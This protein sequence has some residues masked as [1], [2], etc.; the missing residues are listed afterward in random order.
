MEIWHDTRAKSCRC[1]G[2]VQ[3]RQVGK[4][5]F[6][7]SRPG[8]AT[9]NPG[10][11]RAGLTV[12]FAP[13]STAKEKQERTTEP[14]TCRDRGQGRMPSICGV[15]LSHRAKMPPRPSTFPHDTFSRKKSLNACWPGKTNR[16]SRR[17]K[18][19]GGEGHRRVELKRKHSSTVY[20]PRFLVALTRAARNQLP[21]ISGAKKNTVGTG[22]ALLRDQHLARKPKLLRSNIPENGVA[23][24]ESHWKCYRTP[25]VPPKRRSLA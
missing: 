22:V 11:L 20:Q 14:L 16:D 24:C 4:C 19:T 23:R 6:T 12:E 5:D 15:R 1:T 25:E 17:Q 13:I 3:R 8:I 10:I 9:G 7:I 18:G 2:L 21:L